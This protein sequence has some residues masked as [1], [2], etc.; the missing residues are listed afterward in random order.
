MNKLKLLWVG[1]VIAAIITLFVENHRLQKEVDD[2]KSYYLQSGSDISQIMLMMETFWH[3][4]P[5]EFERIAR[6]VVR[7]ELTDQEDGPDF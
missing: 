6:E 3:E 7:E 2:F 1:F 4:A 5:T